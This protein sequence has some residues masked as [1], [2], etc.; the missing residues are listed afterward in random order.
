MNI[1]KKIILTTSIITVGAMAVVG[2]AELTKK[3]EAHINPELK[4]TIDGEDYV[5]REEDGR[6]VPPIIYEGRT[7]LPVRFIAEEAGMGVAWNEET[8]TVILERK[9]KKDKE[10]S[11]IIDLKAKYELVSQDQEEIIIELK[12]EGDSDMVLTFN[13]SKQFDLKLIQD[14]KAVYTWSSDKRFAQVITNKT[15]KPGESDRYTID[16][17]NLPIKA[18]S[19]EFEFY[20][21]AK[22]LENML[23]LKGKV[24]LKN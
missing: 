13:T 4:I 9:S 14:G 10:K 6:I 17:K 23:P 1:F 15:I 18:G 5:A 12:N 7:Y 19:Y 3:I 2:A 11:G 20:S 24:D 16:L 21:A 8:K 22:E